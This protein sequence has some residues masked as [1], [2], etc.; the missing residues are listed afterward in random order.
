V[1]VQGDTAPAQVTR[2]ANAELSMSMELLGGDIIVACARM[3]RRVTRLAP[4][5]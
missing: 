1:R 2:I 4:P 5:G 3:T